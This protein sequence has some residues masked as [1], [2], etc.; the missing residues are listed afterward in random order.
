MLQYMNGEQLKAQR[1]RNEN[2]RAANLGPD[3]KHHRGKKK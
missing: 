1:Q 2:L 3:K